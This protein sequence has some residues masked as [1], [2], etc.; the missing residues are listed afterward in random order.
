MSCKPNQKL[1]KVGQY[2]LMFEGLQLKIKIKLE[3]GEDGVNEFNA[4]FINDNNNNI[5]TADREQVGI[6]LDGKS[7]KLSNMFPEIGENLVNICN[8]RGGAKKKRKS[9]KRKRSLR[10]RNK[11]RN[12][13]RRRI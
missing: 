2:L 12:S 13:R 6:I 3:E 10:K 5:F 9:R 1:T 4:T 8:T 7:K 11:N